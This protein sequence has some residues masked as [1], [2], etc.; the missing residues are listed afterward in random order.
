MTVAERSAA[1]VLTADHKGLPARAHGLTVGDFVTTAVLGD[2]THQAR[3]GHRGQQ[4]ISVGL[5]PTEGLQRRRLRLI[6]H[7]PL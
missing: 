4:F 6:S 3:I 1:L 5:L 2:H 7:A